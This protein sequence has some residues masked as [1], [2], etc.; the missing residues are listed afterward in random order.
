[1]KPAL[2]IL[3][4]AVVTAFGDADQTLDALEAG[5]SAV[6]DQG[7]AGDDKARA[8]A[9]VAD[10]SDVHVPLPP[11][12]DP[13]VKFLSGSG[14]MLADAAHAAAEQAHLVADAARA[15]RRGLWLAQ[16]DAGDWDCHDF[17]PAVHA[18]DTH[19]SDGIP[20]DDAINRASLRVVKPFF[21]LE[22][23]KNNAFSFLA[24]WFDLRG[25]NTSAAGHGASGMVLL[26][27]AARA[28]QRGTL[29]LAVMAWGA[30]LTP[31]FA[32]H[33]RA[34]AAEPHPPATAPGDGAAVVVLAPQG[35]GDVKAH[36][37]IT[38]L[39]VGHEPGSNGPLPDAHGGALP[40]AVLATGPGG[41]PPGA[42]RLDPHIGDVGLAAD[43]VALALLDAAARRGRLPRP[44]GGTT[45]WPLGT[46]VL[47]VARGPQGVG[48]S[49]RV[50]RCA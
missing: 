45:P 10:A 23:L 2:D 17:T 12:L 37:R 31:P 32:R 43:G 30:R 39:E 4:A 47:L 48:G 50:E 36:T 9:A 8:L 41:L 14:K 15:E 19:D 21:L 5:R 33:E 38:T 6:A 42:F 26:D 13:Q 16:M 7:D 20:T 1:M 34:L 28:M 40:L 11:D 35:T 27:M 25:A 24:S 18:A 49:L 29:D 3:G 46:Q 22:D 44:G